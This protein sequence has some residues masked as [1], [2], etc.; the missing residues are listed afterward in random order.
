MLSYMKQKAVPGACAEA[1]L[2]MMD[3]LLKVSLREGLMRSTNP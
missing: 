3:A 2:D 1:L